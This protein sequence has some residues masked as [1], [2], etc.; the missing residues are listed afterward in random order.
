MKRLSGRWLNKNLLLTV[1]AENGS[2]TIFVMGK[3]PPNLKKQMDDY[4]FRWDRI[5][6]RWFRTVSKTQK[7]PSFLKEEK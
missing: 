5:G 1:R 2:K 3:I 4:G 6:K 7:L